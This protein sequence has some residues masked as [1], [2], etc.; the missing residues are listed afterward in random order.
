MYI[1]ETRRRGVRLSAVGWLLQAFNAF[2]IVGSVF[3]TITGL[4]ASVLAIRGDINKGNTTPP[5]SCADNS[6]S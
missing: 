6:S 4:W 5:F 3:A 2:I 1:Y